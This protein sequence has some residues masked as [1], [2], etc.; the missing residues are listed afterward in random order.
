MSV[1]EGEGGESRGPGLPQLGARLGIGAVLVIAAL[2]LAQRWGA[3]DRRQRESFA[4]ASGTIRVAELEAPVEVLRD[5]R[6]I[7]HI[8]ARSERE[9]W[10]ALGFVH[11]Q[12][13][14]AQMVW[15]R[16]RAQGRTAEV[17]GEA[18]LGADRL[19]RLLDMRGASERS[20]AALPDASRAVLTAYAEGVNAR[21]A[22]IRQGRG[23]PPRVLAV[24]IED[25]EP[26]RPADSL[27]VVKLL[28]WCIGGTLET[29]LVLDDLIQR[30]DSVPARPFF[31]GGA[32]IDFGIAPDLRSRPTPEA[33]AAAHARRSGAYGATRAL[34]RGIGL[35]TGSAWVV[36]GSET[37]SGAPI[38]VADWHVAP[39]IPVLFYE[40]H[41]DAGDL[42][43]AGSTVPGSPIVWA[44]RNRRFAWAGVP[45]SAPV[46]D[47]FI[48]TL[49][50]DRGLYQNGKLWVPI[51]TREEVLRWRDVRGTMRETPLRIRSTR[52]GPLIEALTPSA[53]GSTQAG[54]G[55]PEQRGGRHASRALAWTGARVGD[56]LS[57]MLALLRMTKASQLEAAFAEHHE[58]VLAIAYADRDGDGGVQVAGWLARRPLPTGLVPV[59]GRL[60]AFDWRERVPLDALP[61]QRLGSAPRPWVIA[62][63]QPWPSRGGLSQ[64]EWLWRS[65]DQAA[66]L[67]AELQRQT[68]LGPLDLRRASELLQDDVAQRAPRVIASI[69]AL[70]RQR[71]PLPIEAQEVAALLE[72]W[73]GG[74]GTGSAGAAAYHLVIQHLLE[75]LL[76]EPFGPALFRRY[77]EAP[78]ARPQFAI[79][80]LVLS[81]AK[82]HRAGGWTDQ[83]R[84]GAA[85]RA[86][87]RETWV[88]LNHRLGPS[89]E[90]WSWGRLHRMRF[91]PFGPA[92]LRI[93]ELTGSLRAGG[94]GQT[95]AFA[96]HQPGLSFEVDE[97]SL[98][99]IAMDLGAPDRLLSALAPG[100]SEHPGHPHFADGVG[101]WTASRMSLL[102]TSRIVIEEE[103]AER[104]VLEPAP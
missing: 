81:A 54:D 47:L 13:R 92:S 100:Q 43:V 29:T 58:P 64:M 34:C 11:A 22:R 15:L 52:H 17:E 21:L 49:R 59:Q 25:V 95:L 12:D 67:Q 93:D 27:A 82:M 65:G 7:P 53:D 75:D 63:D 16:R 78:H 10:F 79:E 19:A 94:S 36:A 50:E 96:G 2:L 3:D 32:S 99:R 1:R 84:V 80:R 23:R 48:E 87:L 20:V 83:A 38:L 26:W 51:E 98:H 102:A 74:M 33:Q 69:L 5:G 57:S 37:E 70:A 45:A 35:P 55:D 91:Q 41:L 62:A 73:E 85:A 101:R 6:G 46:S 42:D 97:A 86:S 90:R 103:N 39:A 76:R 40:M 71:G 68:S 72:R 56:G 104:L 4:L 77:L 89:R 24:P 18:A 44:G 88:S 8:A 60:R 66:R 30:L 28:S 9:G 31:P 14:L 61:A